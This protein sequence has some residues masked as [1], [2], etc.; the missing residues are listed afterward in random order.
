MTDP[1]ISQ[2]RSI[3][4]RRHVLTGARRTRQF[5]RGYRFGEGQV[6]AVVR[7]GSLLEQWRVLKACIAADVIVIMQAANTGLTGGSTP[8]GEGYDRDIVIVNAMRIDRLDL[9]HNG[10]QVLSLPGVTLNQMEQ[11]LAE[12]GREPHSVIGSSCIG[13]SVTGGVCNNS[14]GSLIQRGP[15]FTQY[16]LYAQV[17]QSGSLRL[18]NHLGISLG[19]TPEEILGSLDRGEYDAS[20]RLT[21]DNRW[22]SDRDYCNHVRDVGA[23]TPARFN[24]DPRRLFEASGS[25]GKLAVFALRLDTFPKDEGVRVFYVGTNNPDDLTTLRRD[26]LGSFETLPIAAE[27]IH[28]DGFDFTRKYAK[29]L[30]L[31]LKRFGTSRLTSMMHAKNWVDGLTEKLGLGP[32]ISDHV[33]Q[34]MS[35]LS[36]DHLPR[37]M[38]EYRDRYEHHLLL[39]MG[40]AG[41]DEARAYLTEYF[42]EKDGDFFECSV[43]EGEDAFLHRFAFGNAT[44]RYL[45]THRDRVEGILALDVALPR[46]DLDW[47]INLP[48]EID[49]QILHKCICAHFFCHVFHLDFLVRKGSDPAAL[50]EQLLA[51]MA[52]RGIEYPAEHNVGHMYAAKPA[53]VA[54]YR[55][56]DPTNSFNSGIGR[57]S[58]KKNWAA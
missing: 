20:T 53:L 57:T 26:V 32:A 54:F 27:Y 18:V 2:F 35:R 43:Q 36:G 58:K 47:Q 15:A 3:V 6:R 22:A 16:A 11:S 10:E 30:F 21:D 51:H 39:K 49:R 8:F 29:D 40:G 44:P 38:G 37:R 23:D 25:A 41:V 31:F 19:E 48:E 42:R 7:P 24:A 46:N 4:G 12:I 45:A 55:E 56:L 5:R 17:D 13:A 52:E 14:G 28:R 34:F 33:L 9:L 1:L 50:K